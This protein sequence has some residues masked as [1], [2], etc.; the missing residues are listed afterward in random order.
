[1]FK[2][3]DKSLNKRNFLKIINLYNSSVFP[4]RHWRGRGSTNQWDKRVRWK[5]FRKYTSGFFWSANIFPRFEKIAPKKA[6]RRNTFWNN[7]NSLLL[8][9]KKLQIRNPQNTPDPRQKFKPGSQFVSFWCGM[10]VQNK[11]I[12]TRNHLIKPKIIYGRPFQG[13][14]TVNCVKCQDENRKKK[15]RQNEFEHKIQFHFMKGKITLT[16]PT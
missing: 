7:L 12:Q 6:I 15:E 1:M 11:I 2:F 3:F 4:W 10:T 9:G 5:W 13:L 16:R 8:R 14:Y